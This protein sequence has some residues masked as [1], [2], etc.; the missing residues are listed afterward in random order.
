MLEQI[1]E[2]V[3]DIQAIDVFSME[4]EVESQMPSFRGNCKR[5]N[6]RDLIS[7]IGVV[8]QR[9]FSFRSPRPLQIRNEQKAA[10]IEE[11]QMGAKFLGFFL[12]AATCS[13]A[14]SLSPFHSFVR[15][16][17]QVFGSSIPWPLIFSKHGNGDSEYGSVSLLL[18]RHVSVSTGLLNSPLLET[19][20]TIFAQ[21]SL[22]VHSINLVSVPESASAVIRPILLH[23][24][25]E[26]TTLWS[27]ARRLAHLLRFYDFHLPQAD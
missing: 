2:K 18:Q 3:F 8:M 25:H 16:V 11:N 26:P 27:S 17:A 1:T 19:R 21:A 13:V 7:L 5:P 23:D 12:S 9:C 14:S 4:P 10:F 24:M 15:P 20:G 22:F 6:G